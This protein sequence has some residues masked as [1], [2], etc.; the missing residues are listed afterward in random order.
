MANLI[1]QRRLFACAKGENTGDTSAD[2]QSLSQAVRLD[3][4]KTASIHTD[5][6][7]RK[8]MREKKDG[9]RRGT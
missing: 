5:K 4:T 1:Q 3:I 9:N 2:T 6:G 8:R 7:E